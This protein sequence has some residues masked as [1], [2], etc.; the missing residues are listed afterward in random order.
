MSRG[1]RT[2]QYVCSI[3]LSEIELDPIA[4]THIRNQ[5]VLRAAV[6]D[7]PV[8]VKRD[9]VRSD[10]GTKHTLELII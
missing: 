8:K 10:A 1:L 4:V 7:S 3:F 2:S 9:C 5:H 6:L